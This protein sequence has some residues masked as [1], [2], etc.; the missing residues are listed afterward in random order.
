[1]KLLH[2][3]QSSELIDGSQ[4]RDVIKWYYTDA[5]VLHVANQ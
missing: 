1:M 2:G 5:P 3:G 4:G